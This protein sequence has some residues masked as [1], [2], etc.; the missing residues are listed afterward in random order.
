VKFIPFISLF[1]LSLSLHGAMGSSVTIPTQEHMKYTFGNHRNNTV[2]KME[3]KHY[4]TSMAPMNEEDIR[5]H[6]SEEGYRVRG[7]KLRDIAS[8]LVYQVYATDAAAKDFKLYVD[9]A[10]GSILK[11]EPIQ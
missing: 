2:Q 10:N 11:M 6:L 1:L 9:P 3:E 8:E 4:Y 7:V 5:N